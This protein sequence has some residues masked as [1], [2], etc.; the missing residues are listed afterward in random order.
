MHLGVSPSVLPHS[1][2]AWLELSSE[3]RTGILQRCGF[4]APPPGNLVPSVLYQ[5]GAILNTLN[6]GH[7]QTAY[8]TGT[9]KHRE[10]SLC[11]FLRM[12]YP[13]FFKV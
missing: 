11:V 10:R 8:L 6:P 3:L 1:Q 4:I 9:L 7:L 12:V 2:N 13:S 5:N